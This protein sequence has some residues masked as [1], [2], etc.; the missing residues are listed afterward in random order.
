MGGRQFDIVVIGGG[1]N[2]VA[3]AREC[4]R[5]GRRT[6]LVEQNDFASGTTSRSTRI[7]HGGLRYLEHGEIGL[8]RESLRERQRLAAERPHLVRPLHFVL[9]MPQER[10]SALELRLGLWL[11]RKL[12]GS[13]ATDGRAFERALEQN[14]A[15]LRIFHYDDAQ[16]E[17]PERLVAE[18]LRDTLRAGGVVRNHT[19][20]IGLRLGGGRV[21]QVILR[22]EI[23]GAE[24]A[25]AATFVINATGP[26]A[27]MF[28][29][30]CGVDTGGRM[31]G[32][33]RGSHLVL[34][35][36][37]GAP[38]TA[39]YT[40]AHDGR[41][42]FLVPWNGQLLFGTTEVRDDGDPQRTRPSDDEI[43]YL[44][45]SLRK[46]WPQAHESQISFTFSGVRPLLRAEGVSAAAVTRRHFLRD[47]ACD[48]AQGLISVL[49]GKLTTAAS[50]A[51]E[52][53]RKIGVRVPKAPVVHGFIGGSAF[54]ALLGQFARDVRQMAHMDDR[55][56]RAL[57]AWHG[58]EAIHIARSIA[59]DTRRRKPI[60]QGASHVVGEAVFAAER[61]IAVTLADILLRRVPLA[62]GPDWSELRTREAARN[63]GAGLRWSE[64]RIESEVEAFEEERSA[65]LLRPAAGR[66]AA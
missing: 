40:V 15:A 22:D 28:C 14:S 53:A 8:V 55:Q 3:I 64:H 41:P 7:I 51:R 59:E 48:G 4:A 65:F 17:F 35:R 38:T 34:S 5:A 26:W 54:D 23:G 56:A 46:M 9:A 43:I 31:I 44:F 12:G 30:G 33:V 57:V 16:C 52:C 37:P 60:V 2:G 50:L 6:L 36:F 45:D 39:V 32:G 29:G 61:E 24:Y 63:I 42:V 10:R 1:I 27:D 47:H 19:S 25:V 62:L 20:A 49:G 58:G 11:Y 21:R 18:W 13:T 66:I